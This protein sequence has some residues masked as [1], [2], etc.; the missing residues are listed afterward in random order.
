MKLNV[1]SKHYDSYQPE[2]PIDNQLLQK[3][4]EVAVRALKME[5]LIVGWSPITELD[6]AGQF[7]VDL[8]ACLNLSPNQIT[9]LTI[10]VWIGLEHDWDGRKDYIELAAITCHEDTYMPI[11]RYLARHAGILGD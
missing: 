2:C 1:L 4:L 3:I 10:P 7:T 9:R 11:E 6:D 8:N 5:R